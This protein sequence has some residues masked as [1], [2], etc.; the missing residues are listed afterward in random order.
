VAEEE[1]GKEKALVVKV[2]LDSTVADSPDCSFPDAALKVG[3]CKRAAEE[4]QEQ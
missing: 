2:L 4:E 1:D 3:N